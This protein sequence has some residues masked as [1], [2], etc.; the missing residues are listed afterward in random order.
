MDSVG[1][2]LV[3]A[4]RNLAASRNRALRVNSFTTTPNLTLAEYERQTS[5]KCD[6]SYTS[7]DELKTL[8]KDAW[9]SGD[10]LAAIYTLRRIWTEGG[11]I[12]KSIDSKDIG[13]YPADL[14][15]LADAV[16]MAVSSNGQEAFRSG[17]L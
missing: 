8:E 2:L 11:T 13:M 3:A 6:V 10:P 9:E 16:K 5:T 7:L 12:Y 15:S 1:K 17:D 4:V 14:D